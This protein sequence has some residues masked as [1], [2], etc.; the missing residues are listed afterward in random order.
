MGRNLR[1]FV[2]IRRCVLTARSLLLLV[3]IILHNRRGDSL[4][5][6]KLS[7]W[8]TRVIAREEFDPC[9]IETEFV[10]LVN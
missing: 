8:L 9:S 2:I 1:A 7:L 6:R 4:Q 5:G 3:P 10:V